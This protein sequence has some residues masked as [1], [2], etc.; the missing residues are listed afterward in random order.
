LNNPLGSADPSGHLSQDQID[1]YLQQRYGD[2]WQTYLSQWKAN[3]AWWAAITTAQPGDY[4]RSDGQYGRLMPQG[5][6]GYSLAFD[7]G[8]RQA[9]LTAWAGRAVDL[10]LHQHD[11]RTWDATWTRPAPPDDIPLLL[12]SVAFGLGLQSATFVLF[13]VALAP[14]P[15]VGDALA[16]GA[17]DVAGYLALGSA[18]VGVA[19]AGYT[20][21]AGG[22]L[23]ADHRAWL[24]EAAGVSALSGAAGFRALNFALPMA[25]LQLGADA[26]AGS[27]ASQT[28]Y[29]VDLP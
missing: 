6:N 26:L 2:R 29:S 13:A 10:V 19:S 14:I 11:S 7:K 27:A 28:Y 20:L 9:P 21:A 4:L 15:A 8:I 18:F 22:L 1:A 23:I 17:L 24:S 12:D 16:A 25:G 3:T 5:L